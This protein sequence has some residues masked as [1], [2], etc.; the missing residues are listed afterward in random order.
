MT[1]LVSRAVV[2]EAREQNT[3]QLS[4]RSNRG[5]EKKSAH[6]RSAI[7]HSRACS[8]RLTRIQASSQ[9]RT[10]AVTPNRTVLWRRMCQRY[11]L[12]HTRDND[13]AASRRSHVAESHVAPQKSTIRM[14]SVYSSE[15]ETKPSVTEQRLGALARSSKWGT[16]SQTERLD[17][18]VVKRADT[19]NG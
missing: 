1:R 11:C 2:S 4:C 5:T 16:H 19:L 18:R 10:T 15:S 7:F 12:A 17:W 13:G 6:A 8:A 3:E 14:N 9:L